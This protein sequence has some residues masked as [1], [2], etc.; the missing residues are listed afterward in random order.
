[1]IFGKLSVPSSVPIPHFS[2]EFPKS[3]I[4]HH[5]V[6]QGKKSSYYMPY[7]IIIFEKSRRAPF[8]AFADACE[9]GMKQNGNGVRD[10][11]DQMMALK[12]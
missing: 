11:A 7:P 8:W 5:S 12:G 4:L 6:P 9:R 1:M 10:S 3:S 2:K